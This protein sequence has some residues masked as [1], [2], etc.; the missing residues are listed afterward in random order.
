MVEVGNDI[1]ITYLDIPLKFFE[2]D[3]NHN[4]SRRSKKNTV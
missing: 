1:I 4:K 3:N 2:N